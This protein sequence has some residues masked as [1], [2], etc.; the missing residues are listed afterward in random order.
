[1]NAFF[2][3]FSFV[4]D[5]LPRSEHMALMNEAL[6]HWGPGSR[7]TWAEG[8]I[9]LG[10]LGLPVAPPRGRHPNLPLVEPDLVLAGHIRLDDREHL[11]S[12][13]GVADDLTDS[14][15]FARAWR[16]WGA[17][18]AAHVFGDWVCAVWDR[19]ARSLWLGRDA[20][21]FTGLYYWHDVRR[22]I[23]STSLKALLAHPDVPRRPDAYAIA[24]L[25]AVVADFAE[26]S[27]TPYQDIRRLPGG[28]A[29]RC[30]ERGVRTHGWWQPEQLP[31]FTWSCETDYYAAF[32]EVYSAA[33]RD[34]LRRDEGPVALMLSA[35]LDS[36]SV[37]ALAAPMLALGGD[38]LLGYVAV[39]R[40]AP[41]GAGRRHLGNEGP[42]ARRV[43]E[44]IGNLSVQ[45]VACEN[46]GIA[47]SLERMLEIHDLPV[48]AA[49]NQFWIQAI[50][51]HCQD[52]GAR[53]LLTGQGGNGTVSWS[54]TGHLRKEL[55][56]LGL[57]AAFV[58]LLHG[59]R[60]QFWPLLKA[61]VLKPLLTQLHRRFRPSGIEHRAPA[62]TYAAI[63]ANLV[64]E[65]DLVARMR[66]AGHV[67][68][69][70]RPASPGTNLVR[71]RLR[72]GDSA[73]LGAIWMN[74][75]A[76]HGLEVRDPTRDRR[77]IE[78]CWRVP[79]RI[80]WAH[81][82]RRGLIRKGMT[83]VLP[84][85]LLDSRQRGRQ[86]ADIG[87]RVL[88]DREAILEALDRVERHAL[89]SAWLDI[90]KMRAVLSALETG[91]TPHTS[92]QASAILLR[93]LGVGLFLTRF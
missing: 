40:F 43:A 90:P 11:S 71:V 88:A 91:V 86:A 60:G 61:D 22:L 30:N 57:G 59:N 74:S 13:L 45:T 75:G 24:R 87:Y 84:P 8:P 49:A 53:V 81:G 50:L 23:F 65:T 51:Q 27:A 69:N 3:E 5:G 68:A 89:A 9:A 77:V 78:F 20:A 18:C 17:D 39:P 82:V 64:A 47:R 2:G 35:G 67:S 38:R 66:A 21:G 79:D 28:H 76:A 48:H 32:R 58:D 1:M 34:C 80:F 83:D 85:F 4:G 10:S 73:S 92:L 46:A 16:R 7:E 41:D 6:A 52:A 44:Y 36:C 12:T 72:G 37:A 42:R 70:N 62:W 33:V 93:G 25:L 31:A 19:Q 56:T 29:L 54:G 15:L 55:R 26:D 63:H 14:Q